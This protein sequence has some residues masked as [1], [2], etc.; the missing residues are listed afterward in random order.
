M[1][2]ETYDAYDYIWYLPMIIIMFTTQ[3]EC[4]V[5]GWWSDKTTHLKMSPWKL[6]SFFCTCVWLCSHWA[7]HMMKPASP[8]SWCPRQPQ[9]TVINCEIHLPLSNALT[10]HGGKRALGVIFQ[11]CDTLASSPGGMWPWDKR[12]K[13]QAWP[14]WKTLCFH[15]CPLDVWRLY[16]SL[17]DPCDQPPVCAG[18][19]H[20]SVSVIVHVDLCQTYFFLLLVFMLPCSWCSSLLS[21]LLLPNLLL[22]NHVNNCN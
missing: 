13:L 4:E 20:Y 18:G 3:Y 10:L 9:Q 14:F 7:V 19:Y 11:K 5:L 17:D 15:T 22:P 6:G 1:K 2:Y 16:R 21:L 8:P 12:S